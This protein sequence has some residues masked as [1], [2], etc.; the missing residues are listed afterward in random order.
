[1]AVKL[2]EEGGVANSPNRVYVA[3]TE[4]DMKA[5]V[6]PFGTLCLNLDDGFFYCLGSA[7]DWKKIS[8]GK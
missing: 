4:N 7:G 2:L 8:G 6:A 3:D 5:L 1:M